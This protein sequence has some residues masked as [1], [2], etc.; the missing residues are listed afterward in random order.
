MNR[1]LLGLLVL[2]CSPGACTTWHTQ[3]VPGPEARPLPTRAAIRITRTDGHVLVLTH[4]HVIGDSLFGEASDP[5]ETVAMA[6]GEI[7]RMER[8]K[9]HAGRTVALTVGVGAVTFLA[10]ILVSVYAYLGGEAT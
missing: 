9:V 7:T 5:P 1:P 8:Q 4:A 10:A 2:L 3:P 6:M